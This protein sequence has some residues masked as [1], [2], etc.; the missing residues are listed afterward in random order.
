[1]ILEELREQAGLGG[2]A[3]QLANDILVITE[4]YQNGELNR[5]EFEYLLNEI[6]SV[7]AQ[8]E[9]ADDEITCRWVVQATQAVL[10]IV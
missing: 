8:Q 1:M 4:Q 10:S 9:L 2:A 3:A 5:E 7:R 6:A